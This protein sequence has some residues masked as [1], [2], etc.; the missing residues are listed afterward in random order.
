MEIDKMQP[1]ISKLEKN[2]MV[3]EGE[4]LTRNQ[5]EEKL[6]IKLERKRII[7]WTTKRAL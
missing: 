4:L 5:V 7:V 2:V 3:I 6:K 1:T